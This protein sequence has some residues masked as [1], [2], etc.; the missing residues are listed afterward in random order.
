VNKLPRPST[1]VPRGDGVKIACY[2]HRHPLDVVEQVLSGRTR[3]RVAVVRCTAIKDHRNY[4]VRYAHCLEDQLF[5]RTSYYQSFEKMEAQIHAK[6]GES[7]DNG[8]LIYTPDVGIL[9]GPLVDGAVWYKEAPR[10]DVVWVAIPS[11]PRLGEQSQYA[12]DAQKNHMLKIVDGVFA[13]A[14]AQEVDVLVLPPLGCGTPSG[15][16][17]PP[18]DV[19]HIIHTT[20]HRY[21]QY[22]PQVCVASD[23]PH[24]FENGWWESFVHAAQ[25]GRPPIT[26]PGVLPVPA[27]PRSRRQPDE[28]YERAVQKANALRRAKSSAVNSGKPIRW[29]RLVV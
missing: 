17:H 8:G 6:I 16:V 1:L 5:L 29:P 28:E 12:C 2:G 19:A 20:A 18:L 27:F 15:C 14:A 4:I 23:W 3:E 21:G 24:H 25:Y 9:R 7:L 13:W 11:Q 10:A 22:I 26:R